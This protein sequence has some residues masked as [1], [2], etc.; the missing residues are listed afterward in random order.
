MQ[1]LLH[2]QKFRPLSFQHSSQRNSRPGA[3]HLGNFIL[4]DIV[5]EQPA[6]I[7][8]LVCLIGS[9]LLFSCSLLASLGLFNPGLQ[10]TQ[11]LPNLQHFAIKILRTFPSELLLFCLGIEPRKLV[12]QLFNFLAYG[13]DI[14]Q[15]E[16]LGFPLFPQAGQLLIESFHFFFHLRTFRQRRLFLFIDKLPMC[17]FEL[18]QT[19]LDHINRFGNTFFFHRQ[20]APSLINKINGLVRQKPVGDVP[21]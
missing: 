12:L 14:F 13:L 3:H 6:F 20:S 9:R 17:E 5:S 1:T 18:P 10:I 7:I 16:F 4:S 2:H 15:P 11:T 19:S 8:S 21:V